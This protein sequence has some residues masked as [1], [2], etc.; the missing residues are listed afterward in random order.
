LI[1]KTRSKQENIENFSET[2][3]KLYKERNV[4]TKFKNFEEILEEKIYS[5]LNG[6][7]NF[8]E[9]ITQQDGSF[10]QIGD[11]DSG[12]FINRDSNMLEL[13]SSI[14]NNQFISRS[15][16]T[17][18]KDVLNY[19]KKIG[20]NNNSCKNNF[21][22]ETNKK[23]QLNLIE[24][25]SILIPVKINL[26]KLHQRYFHKF[27]LLVLKSENTYISFRCG[28]N[29]GKYVHAHEDQL[30]IELF[31]EGKYFFRDKGSFCYTRDKQKR[32]QY[33]S[34]ESHFNPKF[35]DLA[36]GEKPGLFKF[37]FV[38]VYEISKIDDFEFEGIWKINERTLTRR[39]SINSESIIIKDFVSIEHFDLVDN[40][41]NFNNTLFSPEYGI[42]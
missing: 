37:K 1:S 36:Q 9:I 28:L 8:N 7:A 29:H 30:S 12:R 2:L 5:T 40:N 3:F 11:N 15:N 19:F 25:Q 23:S 26:L 4:E 10:Q 24:F 41:Q 22:I 33:R 13:Y 42:N 32:E 38:G 35:K 21:E 6:A 17:I 20:Y 16:Y 27:G 34:Q 31:H 39:L 14:F 18:T